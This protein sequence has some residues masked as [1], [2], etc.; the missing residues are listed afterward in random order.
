MANIEPI[1]IILCRYR[2]RVELDEEELEILRIWLEASRSH[3]IFFDELS[4]N[5]RWL[6]GAKAGNDRERISIRLIKMEKRVK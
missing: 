1:L 2:Q 4:D 5:T 3:E 6:K